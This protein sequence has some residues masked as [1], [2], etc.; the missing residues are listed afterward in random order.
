MLC[1]RSPKSRSAPF[2]AGI[3]LKVSLRTCLCKLVPV[4]WAAL[5]SFERGGHGLVPH[6][7]FHGLNIT[8]LC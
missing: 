1:S 7:W 6:G 8:I 3:D 2:P 5:G 4:A